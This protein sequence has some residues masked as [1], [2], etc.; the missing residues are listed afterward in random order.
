M[1]LLRYLVQYRFRDMDEL[2]RNSRREPL[3]FTGSLEGK[4]V[5]LT[6]ATS[7]IGRATALLFAERGAEL[8]LLNRSADKSAL[9]EAELRDRFGARVTTVLCDFASLEQVRG[10]A[11]ALRDLGKTFDAFI[12]NAGVY[13][14]E[15]TFTADG[16]ETVFQVNHLGVFV[17]VYLL[18]DLFRAQNRARI[19]FVN[20]EGHRFAL[21][22]VHLDDL[23][24]ERHRYTGL[25]SY[26]AAKTAQLLSL[27]GFT[28]LFQGSQVTINAMHPGNVR[29]NIGDQNGPRYQKFKERFVLKSALGPEVSARALLHLAAAPEWA[30]VTGR[31]FHLTTEE[32]P[33]PH[34]RDRQ[35]AD[36]VWKK[37]LE[38]GGLA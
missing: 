19:L 36:L 3:E 1:G 21:A 26:G 7:G 33:A 6:G 20:S 28:D 17:L 12:P 16:I 24:W 25:K 32:K 38:W 15:R 14:T 8:I 9:L 11:A 2:M 4:V 18:Q 29:S 13:Y 30:G 23:D 34:A 37:S 35:A 10:A 22:G 27:F 31:F 5:V